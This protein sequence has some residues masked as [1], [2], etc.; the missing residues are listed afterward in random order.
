M[1]MNNYLKLKL[2][3]NVINF[4]LLEY[5]IIKNTHNLKKSFFIISNSN[6]L[7]RATYQD[8]EVT[9]GK[10]NSRH[11]LAQLHKPN[12]HYFLLKLF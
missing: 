3:W 8:S 5:K 12:C 11:L 7:L 9:I 1:W 6:W 10:A 4:E 2:I